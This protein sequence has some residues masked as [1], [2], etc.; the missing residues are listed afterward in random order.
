MLKLDY[1]GI[2]FEQIGPLAAQMQNL[3]HPAIQHSVIFEEFERPDIQH[4]IFSFVRSTTSL[5]KT[6]CGQTHLFKDVSGVGVP[7]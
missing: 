1:F 3:V 6:R 7:P 5:T 4:M 2:I